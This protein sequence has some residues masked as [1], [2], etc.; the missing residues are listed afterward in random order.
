MTAYTYPD[1]NDLIQLYYKQY[2]ISY[3]L[4][5]NLTIVLRKLSFTGIALYI[6]FES[7]RIIFKT[8]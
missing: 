4:A 8:M 1:L 7:N 3:R 5:F 6:N 2:N